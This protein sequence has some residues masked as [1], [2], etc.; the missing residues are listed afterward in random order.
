MD[1]KGHRGLP[2]NHTN[3]KEGAN[4]QRVYMATVAHVILCVVLSLLLVVS[5]QARPLRQP[6]ATSKQQGTTTVDGITAIYNL[7]HSNQTWGTSS[8]RAP[9]V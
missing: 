8:G 7:G 5:C 2:P 4:K 1:K 3:A 9:L 6:T